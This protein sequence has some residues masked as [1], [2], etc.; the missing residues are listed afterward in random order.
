M[1]MEK[2]IKKAWDFGTTL[3]VSVFFLV[4]AGSMTTG[5]LGLPTWLGAIP[6]IVPVIVGWIFIVLVGLNLIMSIWNLF[7]K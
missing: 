6:E 7:T 2:G 3:I 1:K 5:T 4:L